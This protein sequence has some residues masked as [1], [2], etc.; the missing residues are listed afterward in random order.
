MTGGAG[1]S[2]APRA[3]PVYVDAGGGKVFAHFS[4]GVTVEVTRGQ[5]RSYPHLAGELPDTQ[6]HY[7]RL[8]RSL[9]PRQR[10]IDA[11][12]GSGEGARRLSAA[13]ALVVG[14]DR[15]RHA[16]TFARQF[17]PAVE[18]CQADL[19][20]SLPVP[21]AELVVC[22]DVLGHCPHPDRVLSSLRARLKPHGRLLVLERQAYPTQ[23]LRSPVRRAYS[24]ASLASLLLRRGFLPVSDL[25]MGKSLLSLEC[26]VDANDGWTHL[27]EAAQHLGQADVEAAL[28][29]YARA[30]GSPRRAVQLEALLGQAALWVA[31]ARVAQADSLLSEAQRLE[32]GDPRP[33]LERARLALACRRWELALSLAATALRLDPTDPDAAQVVARCADALEHPHAFASY[34]L[35][36]GLR[37]DDPDLAVR[38][39]QLASEQHDDDY[40]LFVLERQAS[41]GSPDDGRV[42][43]LRAQLL[44]RRGRA[45]AARAAAQAACRAFSEGA[46][47]PV[48]PDIAELAGRPRRPSGGSAATG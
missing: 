42:H 24:A 19:Q 35:A 36:S 7:A 33:L 18:L 48:P 22:A 30:L 44:A 31:Q 37:P 23:A 4:S 16:L 32:P 14:V 45:A 43:V 38:L 39:G 46:G 13:G 27:Q 10:V 26:R 28:Q 5:A 9:R 1:R 12:C 40:A 47:A 25:E 21:V 6:A 15:D 17:A 34:R 11:G 8:A 41:Y 3:D 29:S 2:R 20:Q